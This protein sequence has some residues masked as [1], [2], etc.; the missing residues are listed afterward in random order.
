MYLKVD[1]C[2]KAKKEFNSKETALQIVV[3]HHISY[4]ISTHNLC[5]YDA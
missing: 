5:R 3:N 2:F 1:F 4:D